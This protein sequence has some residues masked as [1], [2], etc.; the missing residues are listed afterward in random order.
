MMDLL[1]LINQNVETL[2]IINELINVN[3]LIMLSNIFL[4]PCIIANRLYVE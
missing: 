2:S 1:D 4:L 3:F